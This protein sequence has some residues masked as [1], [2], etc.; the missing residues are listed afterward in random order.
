MTALHFQTAAALAARI[1][2]REIG[3]AEL[4][5]IFLERTA[6]FNPDLNAIVVL[7]E[8]EARE[9]A[10]EAD[11]A[12]AR[13]I[14]WGPLHGVPMTIKESFD[15]TGTPSTWGVVEHRDNIAARDAVA[16]DRMKQAG[17]TLFG[18]T[19]VPFMLSD[20]QSFNEIYGTTNNPWDLTRTPGGSSGGG[21]G[22]RRHWLQA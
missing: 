2:A 8:E 9:R 22:H 14:V 6:R 17:V 5:E 11:Q 10:S 1:R 16:V 7:R 18:K 13:G 12:L 4:L 15:V 19:N 3:C 21:G 20:W